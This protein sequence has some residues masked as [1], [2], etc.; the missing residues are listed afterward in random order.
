MET[1][2]HSE[3]F[4]GPMVTPD[5]IRRHE[6]HKKSLEEFQSATEDV[7]DTVGAIAVD[8]NGNLA[9]AVSTGGISL[10]LPGRIG[11]SAIP[12]CGFWISEGSD[13][14]LPRVVCCT[15]GTGEQLIQTDFARSLCAAITNGARDGADR[16]TSIS[17]FLYTFTNIDFDLDAAAGFICIVQ[18]A[19]DFPEFWYGFTTPSMGLGFMSSTDTKPKS[20][21]DRLPAGN[22]FRLS[23]IPIY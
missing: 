15:T 13:S 22:R 16:S 11:D 8:S 17:D 20:S 23:G 18:D 5:A 2:N 9:V 14:N 7:N 12:G 19:N 3:P 10:K 6:N 21:I 4:T 1:Y